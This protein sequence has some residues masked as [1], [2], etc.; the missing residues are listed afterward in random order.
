MITEKSKTTTITNE[1]DTLSKKDNIK[2][3]PQQI[4]NNFAKKW[5][6]R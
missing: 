3:S 4:H 5:L 6:S 1:E 2:S